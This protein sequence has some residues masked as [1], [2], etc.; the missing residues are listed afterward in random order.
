M[1]VAVVARHSLTAARD[2]LVAL[3]DWLRSHNVD[4]AWTTEAAA[5]MPPTERAIIDRE[6]IASDSD[7]V[8]VL[9]GDGTLLA[10]AQIIA[11]SGRDVPILGV[12]FGSLGFLTEI[13]LAELYPALEATLEGRATIETRTML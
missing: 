12:N 1:R 10:A 5:L 7:L 3:D 6:D 8:I 9:G 4:V 2:T 11:K 13:T